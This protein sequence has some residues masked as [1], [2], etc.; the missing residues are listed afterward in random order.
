MQQEFVQ[1]ITNTVRENIKG[2][3]TA[4][5]GKIVSF[6]TNTGL[7]T[8][9][10]MMKFK[11]SSGN[12]IDYPQITGV[13]VWMPQAMGQQATIAYPI[14]PNDGCIL[15]FAE[16]SID[17]WM[18]GQETNTDLGFDLTNAICVPGLFPTANSAMKDA[19]DNNSIVVDVNG[20]RLS[21]KDGGISVKGNV[22]VEGNLSVKGDFTTSGGTVRLN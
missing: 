6:D 19:C 17:Y 14:K 13:P 10:P 2:L 1:E 16:Q 5:P 21:V 20:T 22:S 11:A 18:Y 7:A 15:I 9:L 3:H 4:C 12:V 8:V